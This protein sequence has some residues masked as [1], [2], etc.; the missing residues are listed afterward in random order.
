MSSQPG[1]PAIVLIDLRRG[2]GA[3]DI[4]DRRSIPV[5]RVRKIISELRTWGL[6]AEVDWKGMPA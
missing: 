1:L 5:E 3:E 4:A 2:F 6:L